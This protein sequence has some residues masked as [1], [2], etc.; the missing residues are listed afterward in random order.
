MIQTLSGELALPWVG[1]TH[2]PTG[3]VHALKDELRVVLIAV[4][5]DVNDDEFAQPAT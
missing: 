4:Q 2:L 5:C 1:L 3:R